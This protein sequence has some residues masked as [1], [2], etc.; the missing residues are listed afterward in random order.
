MLPWSPVT[1]DLNLD[2]SRRIIPIKL[3][4]MIAWIVGASEEPTDDE[5]VI[6]K[7][8]ESRRILAIAQDSGTYI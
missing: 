3:F 6:V 8:A 5:F 7:E 1:S 2:S 4:N